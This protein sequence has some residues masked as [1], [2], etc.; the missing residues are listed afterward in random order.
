[1]KKVLLSCALAFSFNSIATDFNGYIVKFKNGSNAINQKSLKTFGDFKALNFSFG[2]FAALSGANLSNKNMKTLANHPEVEYVEPNW[3]IK[4]EA[5]VETATITDPNFSQQWGLQNTGKNSGGWFSPG[6]KGEDV[7]ATRAWTVTKGNKDIIV[8]VIDTGIDYRHPDLKE[9]LWVNEAELNGTAGIDDDGNGYVDDTYGYDFANSD[10]DPLDGHGHGT[11][12]SGVIGAAHN[13]KGVRGVMANV[14]L[15]G[16]KFLTDSGSGETIGAI[17][18]IEYAVKNGAHITSNSWGGGEKSEALKEAIQ[19]A[20]DAGTMFVAA[21]GNSRG[22]NDTKPTYPAAYKVDGIITVG[23]MDGKG[24]KASFSNYGKKSVHVFAPG[25]NILSTVKNGKYQ[26]MSG[27]SMATPFVSGVLG[28]LLS[29]EEGISID[30]AKERL[31]DST[32]LNRS[33]GNYTV[34]GRVDA[35]RML[36]DQRN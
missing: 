10:G 29:H 17:K 6:K 28:L 27:T 18:A 20:Y 32:V 2:N 24:N 1:M 22:N 26:K 12:C 14:K 16:I 15:M 4:V 25:T 11:H 13:Y 30:E 34:T 23:A 3:V 21:A 9:N 36:K 5:K 8:A 31:M 19:A 7:N 35:Y 33:L